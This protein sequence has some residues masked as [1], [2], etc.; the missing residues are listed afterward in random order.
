MLDSGFPLHIFKVNVNIRDE[1]T[2]K[3][4]LNKKT[5]FTDDDIYAIIKVG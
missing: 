3:I 1:E 4:I 2:H 5:E